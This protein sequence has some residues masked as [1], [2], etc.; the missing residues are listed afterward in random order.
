MERKPQSVADSTALAA[1]KNPDSSGAATHLQAA[2]QN[3]DRTRSSVASSLEMRGFCSW[4]STSPQR[5]TIPQKTSD[6]KYPRL[7]SGFCAQNPRG[8]VGGLVVVTESRF[9]LLHDEFVAALALSLPDMH[10]S[11]AL[12]TGLSPRGRGRIHHNR[13]VRFLRLDLLHPL[14]VGLSFGTLRMDSR[15]RIRDLTTDRTQF[16]R[17]RR[18]H[19][20]WFFLIHV[21][22]LMEL[23]T[24]RAWY[25]SRYRDSIGLVKRASGWH[26]P[27]HRE[28]RGFVCESLLARPSR[29]SERATQRLPVHTGNFLERDLHLDR[30]IATY[31]LEA[32]DFSHVVQVQ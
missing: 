3:L 11:A 8:N 1:F 6:S 22:L 12:R 25:Q 18:I 13:L 2:C 31:H 30:F 28:G 24:S 26:V 23:D 32:D 15:R 27:D 9:R 21:I 7:V 17:G 19:R 20:T 16:A 5:T 4:K 29:W 14:L 10:L